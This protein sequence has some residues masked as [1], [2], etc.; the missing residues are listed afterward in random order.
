MV[1]DMIP[2]PIRNMP[3]TSSNFHEGY[4]STIFCLINFFME[5]EKEATEYGNYYYSF[6]WHW[7]LAVLSFSHHF[8]VNVLSGIICKDKNKLYT[9]HFFTLTLTFKVSKKFISKQPSW[10]CNLKLYHSIFLWKT[11]LKLRKYVPYMTW[12]KSDLCWGWI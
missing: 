7:T 10:M 11:F 8:L 2:K 6:Q 5:L 9:G 12:Y 1:T 3:G 4:N